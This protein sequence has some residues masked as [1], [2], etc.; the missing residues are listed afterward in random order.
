MNLKQKILYGF[1]GLILGNFFLLTLYTGIKNFD[2]GFPQKDEITAEQVVDLIKS[3]NIKKINI[4]NEQA[5]LRDHLNEKYSFSVTSD[6][7]RELV[8][9]NV[10]SFNSVN[11]KNAIKISEAPSRSAVF[12]NDLLPYL[13]QIMFILFFISPP[14]IAFLLF[15]IWRELKSR[16]KMK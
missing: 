12:S 8:L 16:N 2:R 4:E 6:S 10:S 7:V 14:I 5:I 9:D 15:L 13:F 11:P 1:V 3:G